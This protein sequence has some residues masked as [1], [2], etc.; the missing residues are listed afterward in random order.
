[1]NIVVGI[2]IIALGIW[3]SYFQTKRFV[4]GVSDSLG[5][6]ISL[7]IVGIGLIGIGIMTFFM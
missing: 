2:I 1:M 5:G 7:L 3:L 4:K 6:N